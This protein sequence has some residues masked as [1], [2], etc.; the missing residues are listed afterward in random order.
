MKNR[1]SKYPGRV[2]LTPEDGSAPFYATI[3]RADEPTEPGDPL[4]KSTFLTDETAALFGMGEAA[5]PD[6]VFK[7]TGERLITLEE[8]HTFEKI[9]EVTLAERTSGGFYIELPKTLSNY[10]LIVFYAVNLTFGA[11]SGGGYN[12]GG[13]YAVENLTS[14]TALTSFL[15]FYNTKH[16]ASAA[17]PCAITEGSVAVNGKAITDTKY[18][19]AGNSSAYIEPGAHFEIWGAVQ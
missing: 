13:L 10:K 2:L 1:L 4:S 15:D 7:Q 19:Y 18:L 17:Y 12:T 9:F 11:I 6:E 8:Q 16:A 14:T 5:V 3:T